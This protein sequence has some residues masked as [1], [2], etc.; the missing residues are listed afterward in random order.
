MLLAS[1]GI[2]SPERVTGLRDAALLAEDQGDRVETRRYLAEA[3]RLFDALGL[4]HRKCQVLSDLGNVAHDTGD[5]DTAERLQIE[6][7]Q[8]AIER[9]FARM[10]SSLRPIWEWALTIVANSMRRSIV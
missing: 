1:E 6:A 5:F 3:L 8:L 2:D 4:L 7:N 10:S 9:G